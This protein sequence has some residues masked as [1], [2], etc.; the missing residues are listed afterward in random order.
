MI[1]PSRRRQP[2]PALGS[3]R[4]SGPP[5][6]RPWWVPADQA[7]AES[8]LLQ[9]ADLGRGWRPIP[10]VNNV[11]HLD[12]FGPGEAADALRAARSDRVLTALDEG[13]AWRRRND[14]ILAVARVE[15]FAE[16]DDEAHRAV[17]REL[18]TEV[19]D[20]T[21]RQRWRDR[22]SQPGWI[23]AS[24]QQIDDRPDELRNTPTDA[25][26]DWIVVEDHTGGSVVA[27]EHVTVWCAR[28][29]LTLTVRHLLGVDLRDAVASACLAIVGRADKVRPSDAG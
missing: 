16:V 23:E 20:A 13:Q 24:W 10:M 11:E 5:G 2:G 3:V 26:V 7:W 15:V 17:W 9:T 25:L 8:G 22:D 1:G 18:G 29:Q 28:L 27:Y 21:W 4:R 12:P 6:E 19:L 14:A